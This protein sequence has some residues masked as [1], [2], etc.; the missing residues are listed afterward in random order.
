MLKS[1]RFSRDFLAR[2]LQREIVRAAL[3]VMRIWYNGVA[4][5]FI[6]RF[7]HIASRNKRS[8]DAD[9]VPAIRPAPRIRPHCLPRWERG[10]PISG[11][12][13]LVARLQSKTTLWVSLNARRCVGPIP[14]S[15]EARDWPKRGNFLS[16][17][18]S[19]NTILFRIL[20]K[21]L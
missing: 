21:Q 9:G 5:I 2:T 14:S 16:K 10:S 4:H 18:F 6:H 8:A 1:S 3:T 12:L 11:T 19:R 17:I 20:Y 13:R 7:R 15:V